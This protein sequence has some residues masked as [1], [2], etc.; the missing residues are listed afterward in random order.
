MPTPVVSQYQF[1]S[2]KFPAGFTMRGRSNRV[3]PD[4]TPTPFQF[5][6]HAPSVRVGGKTVTLNGTIGGTGAVDSAGN[7]FTG[8]DSVYA[9]LDLLCSALQNG[10]AALTAG[11]ADLR[12]LSCQAK[13]LKVTAMPG[14]FQRAQQ[15]ELELY[16]PDPR[17]IDPTVQ[18]YSITPNNTTGVF[19]PT[20]GSTFAFPKFVFKDA[21][22][23]S[24]AAGSLSFLNAPQ[25]STYS[26]SGAREVRLFDNNDGGSLSM[27]NGDVLIFDC[28]PVAAPACVTLNGAPRMDLLKFGEFFGRGQKD[29]WFMPI[30]FPA[31]PNYP[32]VP[33]ANIVEIH[34]QDA[35]IL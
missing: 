8:R 13:S 3:N 19:T 32:F 20:G 27:I 4:L 16:A 25:S 5:G 26:Y 33:R 2:Y 6:V 30:V 22:T 9:E 21:E 23:W 29:D 18:V 28:D 1:G 35:W 15:I 14:T 11:N 24:L 31:K 17:W 12:A 34:W 7:P 10:Y